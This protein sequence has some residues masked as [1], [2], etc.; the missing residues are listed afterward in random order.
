MSQT[1]SD[2]RLSIL[3]PPCAAPCVPYKGGSGED[4]TVLSDRPPSKALPRALLKMDR[5]AALV[6]PVPLHAL[7]YSYPQLVRED[8]LGPSR[9][10]ED[11]DGCL[12][13]RWRGGTGPESEAGPAQGAAVRAAVGE[14]RAFAGHMGLP[15]TATR[16]TT[17]A[18]LSSSS[19]TTVC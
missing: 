4:P 6:P 3:T 10:G 17:T 14:A 1:N 18:R 2:M 16:V 11:N 19:S 5:W 8:S 13:L 12:R 7:T 9:A 15:N